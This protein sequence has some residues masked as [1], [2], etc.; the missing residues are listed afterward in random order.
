[1]NALISFLSNPIL[2]KAVLAYWLFNAAVAAL[3]QPNGG[4]FYQFVYRFLHIL[5][6]NIDR[7]AQKLNIPGIG[8]QDP[9]A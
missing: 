2:W 7:A 4:K 6:G 3:P 1:M 5:A 8:P 9:H